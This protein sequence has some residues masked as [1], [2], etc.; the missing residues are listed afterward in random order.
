MARLY[1]IIDGYNLMHAAGIGKT[2][3]GPGDLERRRRQ[4]VQQLAA[5]LDKQA[6]SDAVVI[7]DAVQGLHDQ[8]SPEELSAPLRVRFSQAG[9]DADSEIELMIESHSSPRQVLVISSDHRLH[10][11]ARRRR[12]RCIDSEKFWES[13]LSGHNFSTARQSQQ[14]PGKPRDAARGRT[15]AE[16][17]REDE[18]FAKD[19]LNIDISEIKRSVHRE[20]R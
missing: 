10:K 20:D 3:G 11:A 19:F 16:W 12:A 13:L 4:L 15:A 1:L 6:S 5:R 7:F 17:S 18:D 8:P 9:R 2:S 14:P